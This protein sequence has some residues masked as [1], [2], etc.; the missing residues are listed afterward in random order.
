MF[1]APGA[2]QTVLEA[3]GGWLVGEVSGT[4]VCPV[5][6]VDDLP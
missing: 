2:Y 1:D 6:H 5:Y 4:L 3:L